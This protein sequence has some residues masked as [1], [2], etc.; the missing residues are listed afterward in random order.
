MARVIHYYAH[1]GHQFSH[2]NRAMIDA[3]DSVSDITRV[4]LY[5]EYPRHDIDIE[6]EQARLLEHDVIVF[7]FPLFW[8]SAPSLVKEWIDL[9]LENGF[10]YGDGGDKLSGKVFM[11]ATTMAGPQDAYS[12]EGYQNFPLRVF[13][14]PFEQTANLT[15]MRFVTPY[16]LHSSLVADNAPHAQGFASLLEHLRDDRFDFDRAAKS[17]IITFDTLPLRARG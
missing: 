14:S 16:V 4:D 13:L 11:L 5:A 1:P 17:D 6:R 7:Q 8:Y 9:V 12:V 10:A 3:A 2:A 15:Q